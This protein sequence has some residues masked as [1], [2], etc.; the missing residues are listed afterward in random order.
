MRPGKDFDAYSG[1]SGFACV[2]ADTG[3]CQTNAAGQGIA[4]NIAE[5]FAIAAWVAAWSAMIFLPLRLAGL[6]VASEEVQETGMD[7]S[8]HSPQKAYSLDAQ[9]NTPDNLN[10]VTSKVTPAVMD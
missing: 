1:W 4:A 9:K 8:K 10:A 6:L 7:E 2:K 5:I 3:L